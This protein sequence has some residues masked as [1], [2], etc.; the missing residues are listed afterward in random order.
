MWLLK[1]QVFLHLFCELIISVHIFATTK[2]I[3]LFLIFN[4]KL[5]IWAVCVCRE[6]GKEERRQTTTAFDVYRLSILGKCGYIFLFHLHF[7]LFHLLS[8]FSQNS[9]LRNF[10][11]INTPT[12]TSFPHSGYLALIFLLLCPF[13][14]HFQ[15]PSSPTL[16]HQL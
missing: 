2:N 15:P 7:I 12:V 9:L 5:V 11:L 8:F 1:L 4:W 10:S 16:P 13:P 14:L 6:S 3:N